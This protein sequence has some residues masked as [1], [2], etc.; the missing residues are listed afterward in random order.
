[1]ASPS[2]IPALSRWPRL[3]VLW[4]F[5]QPHRRAVL[6]GLVLG[7][8]ATA[9]SLASPLV[10]K[11]VLDSLA[12]TA[13]LAVPVTALAMLLVV[14]SAL[15][16]WQWILLGTVAE[17][18]V[19]DARESMVRRFFRATIPAITGRP[20]GELVTRV[21]SDTVLLRQAAASSVV[22]LVNGSIALVGTLILMAFLDTVLLAGIV[23]AIAVVAAIFAGLMPTIAA[24]R[25]S[26]QEALGRLGGGLEGALTAIRTVKASRAEDRQA[27][28]VVGEA[29]EAARHSV[30]AVRRE[31]VAWAV[32]WGGVNLAIMGILALGAWRVES[33]ALE[34]SSLVAF[35]LYAF[36][37][38]GPVTQLTQN[39]TALQAGV[40]AAE[41]IREV[42]AM[43]VEP[44]GPIRPPV[45]PP[46][47]AS[48][49]NAQPKVHDHRGDAGAVI[50]LRS[51]TLRYTQAGAPALAEVDLDIPR[52]GHTAI[53]GPSGAGKTSLF[54]LLLR[55]V[56]PDEGE[57]LL[58]GRPYQTLSHAQV[59]RRL[60]YVE[61]ETPVV[62]DSVRDN[63]LLS[64]PQASD[65]DLHDVL[66]DVQLDEK[67]RS[68]EGG[69][70]APLSAAAISGGQRQRV[71]LARAL[72][73]RPDVLLLDEATSS[74]DGL[75]EA[76][77]H[78]CI[79]QRSRDG[80]VVTIAHRLSTVVDADRIVLLDGGRVRAVGTHAELLVR[81]ELYR[82]LVEAL[83]IGVP[84]PMPALSG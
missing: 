54:S 27:E 68:T 10:T 51:V 80:A 43:A 64:E 9:A 83:R 30:R 3:A 24:S 5:V 72:L 31:A 26:A 14:G 20:T 36:L 7:L 28:V 71:A 65:D 81:D 15:T 79:R 53:V 57:L 74:V 49:S 39:V 62:P 21:T 6:L 63:L 59:R 35:L 48:S 76:A 50:A 2:P 78:E 70:D 56:E 38:M 29:K 46:Q 8:L 52:R 22:E 25:L 44:S 4:S 12:G 45:A 60:A 34:V 16:L 32:A 18:I 77:I 37:L 67:V 11:W 19:L 75:T 55:F 84:V 42:Q 82:R 58:D 73:R 41:R 40:A 23:I 61:Q 1:M 69:L 17:R 47:A 13:S 66:R 33:G